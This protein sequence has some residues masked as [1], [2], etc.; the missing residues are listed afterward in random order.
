MDLHEASH[1]VHVA[2]VPQREVGRAAVG[3]AALYVP[4]PHI[5][6]LGSLHRKP[7]GRK[8]YLVALPVCLTENNGVIVAGVGLLA[9]AIALHSLK[10]SAVLPGR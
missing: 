9:A 7:P 1:V 5:P 2:A 8:R 10:D 3:Q 4:G 6:P